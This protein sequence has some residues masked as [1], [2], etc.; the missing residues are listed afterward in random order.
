[1]N[2]SAKDLSKIKGLSD[3][4][5]AQSRLEHG[6]NELEKK[7]KLNLLQQILHVLAEPMFILLLVTASVYFFLGEFTDGIIMLVLVFFVSGIE[8]VSTAAAP[9]RCPD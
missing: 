2:N 4:E 5:V 9:G 7:R 1:M 3:I 6:S 8:F